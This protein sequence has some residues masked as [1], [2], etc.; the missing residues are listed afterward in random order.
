MPITVNSPAW[1]AIRRELEQSTLKLL[2]EHGIA[3]WTVGF[4]NADSRAGQCN[5]TAQRISYS[6]L[7]M[8]TATKQERLNT[9]LH[10]VA[11]AITGPNHG[12]D[13]DWE[14]NFVALGGNGSAFAYASSESYTEDRY[15]WIGVC[16]TCGDRTG[17]HAAPEDVWGCYKCPKTV[18]VLNRVFDLRLRGEPKTPTE[19]GKKYAT[20]YA[21]LVKELEG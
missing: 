15:L 7:F 12:H 6:V 11:H 19:V 18:S 9:M 4:D 2:V 13:A 14:S 8:L 16:P 3:G 17:F 5:F 21:K 10:E 20:S 1:F